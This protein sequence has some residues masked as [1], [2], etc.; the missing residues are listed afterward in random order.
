MI[1]IA[2]AVQYLLKRILLVFSALLFIR[3]VFMAEKICILLEITN[4][5]LKKF[6]YCSIFFVRKLQKPG[7]QM[8]QSTPLCLIF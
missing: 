5:S 3:D 7:W 1:I 2:S 8:R 6:L 4:F